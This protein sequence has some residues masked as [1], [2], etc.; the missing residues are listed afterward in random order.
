MQVEDALVDAH[1]EPVPG[2]GALSAGRL[3][4]D[5]LQLLGGEAHG[6]G[7]LELLLHGALFQVTANCTR[8][9]S[10]NNSM[11]AQV[12][13]KVS[14]CRRAGEVPTGCG[15]ERFWLG[16]CVVR[17]LSYCCPTLSKHLQRRAII[18]PY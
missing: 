17:T 12:E 10:H 5:D 6:P 4:R 11:H 15:T 13:N 9:Q 3:A 2:V 14:S 16:W 7:H 8:R 1:L 18:R